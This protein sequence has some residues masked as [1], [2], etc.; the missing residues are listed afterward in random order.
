MKTQNTFSDGINM[1]VNPVVA[2]QTVMSN[3]L[4]GT[5]TTF[6]GNENVLQNDMGNGKVHS[7]YLPSGWVPVGMAEHGGIIYV[8]AYN[9]ETQ[10]SQLGSFPSPQQNF[11]SSKNGLGE[12]FTKLEANK[13]KLFVGENKDIEL[14]PG[15]K[16]AITLAYE[17]YQ[18]PYKIIEPNYNNNQD[19]H[20]RHWSV[21]LCLL[22][23]NGIL[24]DITDKLENTVYD[25]A[26]DGNEEY[27]NYFFLQDYVEDLNPYLRIYGGNLTGSPYIQVIENLA[28]SMDTFVTTGYKDGTVRFIVTCNIESTSQLYG[29]PFKPVQNPE[30]G[31]I[32]FYYTYI[33][34]NGETISGWKELSNV[35]KLITTCKNSE[36]IDSKIEQLVNCGISKDNIEVRG[37]SIYQKQNYTLT[38]ESSQKYTLNIT[39]TIEIN[40]ISNDDTITLVINPCFSW[41][42]EIQPQT[43]LEFRQVFEVSKIGTGIH[44]INQWRYYYDN[45]FVTLTWGMESYP[46]EGEDIKTLYM[47]F[48]DWEGKPIDFNN[49]QTQLEF[50]YFSYNGEFTEIFNSELFTYKFPYIVRIHWIVGGETQ[51]AYRW[52]LP[53][54]LYNDFYQ[55][56]LV[57]DFYKEWMVTEYGEEMAKL[58]L[59]GVLLDFAN[60]PK[61]YVEFQPWTQ[62]PAITIEQPQTNYAIKNNVYKYVPDF[63]VKASELSQVYP[64]TLDI[65]SIENTKILST[66]D[67]TVITKYDIT[68]T[69]TT[70]HA[71]RYKYTQNIP[72]TKLFEAHDM[73]YLLSR[74]PCYLVIG[75]SRTVHDPDINAI[76]IYAYDTNKRERIGSIVSPYYKQGNGTYEA[77]LEDYWGD[78]ETKLTQL[79]N[80]Y[81]TNGVIPVVFYYEQSGDTKEKAEDS[82]VKTGWGSLNYAIQHNSTEWALYWN[83][84][85]GKVDL[86]NHNYNY[87][88]DNEINVLGYIRLAQKFPTKE[89]TGNS[90]TKEPP[91]IVYEKRHGIPY[92]R[93]S[94]NN[95]TYIDGYIAQNDN[96]LTQD[97]ELE[98]EFTVSADVNVKLLTTFSEQQY[99]T[100]VEN[101]CINQIPTEY[102]DA[103]RKQLKFSYNNQLASNIKQNVT[104]TY[105]YLIIKSGTYE[106][107]QEIN[108]YN[109]QGINTLVKYFK[110]LDTT[111]YYIIP[112]E[113]LEADIVYTYSFDGDHINFHEQP[114]A[115]I[116]VNNRG[117]RSIVS[118]TTYGHLP[119]VLGAKY[120]NDGLYVQIG[121]IQTFNGTSTFP[122]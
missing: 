104:K 88:G 90:Y 81:E 23:S 82:A 26:F 39:D 115:S 44:D 42:G 112:D 38:E 91:A 5:F 9:P 27:V 117:V 51:Y 16:L 10:E 108:N 83:Y 36:E 1:D 34:S 106:I 79:S 114:Q 12:T 41:D 13:Y 78:C 111:S 59:I 8:A 61:E 77:M 70:K 84:P 54:P 50:K 99:N 95:G 76:S 28:S 53:T 63:K 93:C 3:C 72:V 55:A 40:D 119:L 17:D 105:N 118:E 89:E 20:K 65:N 60:N 92:I 19:K 52:I 46:A 11:E 69:V 100:A 37:M 32:G 58:N 57:Q 47:E 98:F 120:K 74:C 96:D 6:N 45:D 71:L 68:H 101:Y 31:L 103:F 107:G 33:K 122:Q 35:A 21:Q 66:Y 110:K 116:F 43:S 85:Y 15:N 64:F 56:K 121:G 97:E 25:Y 49:G 24:T 75:I 102:K 22:T 2:P 67:N 14:K 7:A 113:E 94:H 73:E 48:L 80:Q 87:D 62:F 86:S 30:E 18:V 109:I 29:Y 4:N